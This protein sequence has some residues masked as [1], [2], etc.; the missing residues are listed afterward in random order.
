MLTAIDRIGPPCRE[1]GIRQEIV[2][3]ILDLM[4]PPILRSPV[5]TAVGRPIFWDLSGA[6]S[7]RPP[8][9]PRARCYFFANFVRRKKKIIPPIAICLKG[10]FPFVP[11]P[12]K[13]RSSGPFIFFVWSFFLSSESS[14]LFCLTL[15]MPMLVWHRS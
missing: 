10:I 13:I 7:W 1:V 2:R 4:F 5:P 11:F 12:Q 3:Y 8:L 15:V 14:Y 6:K 9:A